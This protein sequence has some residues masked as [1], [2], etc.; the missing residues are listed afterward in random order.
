MNR[1]IKTKD[2]VY[3]DKLIKINKDLE[4]IDKRKHRN[5]EKLYSIFM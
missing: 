4:Q 1:Q 5:K 2:H 3:K